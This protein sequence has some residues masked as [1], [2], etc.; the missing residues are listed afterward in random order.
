[1]PLQVLV[2][3]PPPALSAGRVACDLAHQQYSPHPLRWLNLQEDFSDSIR[4]STPSRPATIPGGPSQSEIGFQPP[5]HR[6]AALGGLP[7][8]FAF[9][10]TA[11]TSGPSTRPINRNKESLRA[12]KYSRSVTFD[13][14]HEIAAIPFYEASLDDVE[15]DPRST[16]GKTAE[17]RIAGSAIESS[18]F[19][20][21]SEFH[22]SSKTPRPPHLAYFY[23]LSVLFSP[24][25]SAN[26]TRSL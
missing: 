10:S 26:T 6:H 11:V 20:G 5:R 9:S 16:S 19:L 7:D 17:K 15:E 4:S 2:L 12:R 21:N 3:Y 18:G 23:A 1:M 24:P 25:R 8:K 22:V 13:L 14:T